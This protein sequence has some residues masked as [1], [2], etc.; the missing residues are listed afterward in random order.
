MDTEL[1]G[2][3]VTKY[4]TVHDSGRLINPLSAKGQIQGAVIQG[5][6]MALH[7]DLVYDR[8]TGQPLTAGYYGARI[9]THLRCAGR[10]R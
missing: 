9:P 7:E 8:R 1:G 2:V 6:G 10:S 5:I 3:R 4:L